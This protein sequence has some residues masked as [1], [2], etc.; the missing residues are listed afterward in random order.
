MIPVT[1]G[2]AAAKQAEEELRDREAELAK[3]AAIEPY[4]RGNGNMTLLRGE[5]QSRRECIEYSASDPTKLCRT[6]IF[7]L[8]ESI[9]RTQN[10]FRNSLRRWEIKKQTMKRTIAL[11]FPMGLSS[12]SMRSDILSS[13]EKSGLVEFV[14]TVMDITEQHKARAALQTAFEQLKT[15]GNRASENDRRHRQLCLR[16]K[17]GWVKTL[18]ANQT[19]VLDYTGLCF[20]GGKEKTSAHGSLQRKVLERLREER[21]SELCCAR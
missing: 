12:T 1:G 2:E 9:I 11:F 16:V 19:P 8:N 18:Y 6:L 5:S 21:Y 13:T 17:L 10:A 4:R 20:G 3:G 14:G 15:G 7:G